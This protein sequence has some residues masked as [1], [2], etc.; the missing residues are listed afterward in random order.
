MKFKNINA[1]KIASVLTL[2]GILLN[3]L[4]I[5]VIAFNWQ[6]AERYVP[7]WME[8][9]ITLTVICVEIIVLRWIVIRMPIL[10][11]PP[12]WASD[13]KEDKIKKIYLVKETAN[14]NKKKEEVEE[15][16]V[17]SM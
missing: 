10:S 7:T 2:V 17:S 16:K 6:I 8:I 13:K 3:R 1:V 15:W 9:W 12:A 5:S 4:N 11:D 14:K